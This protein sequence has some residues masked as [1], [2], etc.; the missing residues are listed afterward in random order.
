MTE[1]NF[2]RTAAA[3]FTLLGSRNKFVLLAI[4]QVLDAFSVN[5]AFLAQTP[6]IVST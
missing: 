2:H 5:N 4:A 1:R 3:N 6:N